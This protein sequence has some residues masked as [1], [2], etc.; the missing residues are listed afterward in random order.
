MVLLLVQQWVLMAGTDAIAMEVPVPSHGTPKH[1]A[2]G[3]GRT[4]EPIS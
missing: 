3:A 2:A 4:P 1:P